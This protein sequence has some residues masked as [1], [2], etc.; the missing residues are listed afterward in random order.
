MA[1]RAAADVAH[2]ICPVCFRSAHAGRPGRVHQHRAGGAV[3]RGSGADVSAAARAW[4]AR[5]DLN[6]EIAAAERAHA[7]RFKEYQPAKRRYEEALAHLTALKERLAR[8]N[9][10]ER[11]RQRQQPPPPPPPPP[12]RPAFA[13]TL[14]L[15]RWPVTREEII[16]AWRVRARATHPDAGGSSADFIAVQRAY[17]TALAEVSRG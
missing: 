4:F 12:V 10:Q 17:A 1:K 11:A 7:R 5:R 3:C 13:I 14:G 8:L 6:E 15:A 16:A 2:V 9:E